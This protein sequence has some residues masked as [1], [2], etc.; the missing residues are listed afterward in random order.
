[1]YQ[2]WDNLSYN[3]YHQNNSLISGSH[4][5]ES[6]LSACLSGTTVLDVDLGAPYNLLCP[7]LHFRG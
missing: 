1:M 3:I 7:E 5:F 6:S 4:L 2:F